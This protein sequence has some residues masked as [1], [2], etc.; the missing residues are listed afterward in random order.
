MALKLTMEISPNVISSSWKRT[1][2]KRFS[3]LEAC[4]EA[5]EE[6]VLLHQLETLEIQE[7]M[8]NEDND[9]GDVME[10]QEA[11]QSDA[12][13]VPKKKP[14]QSQITSFFAKK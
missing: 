3:T 14:I 8:E 10:V 7:E 1:G 5:D 4:E 11:G 12:S 6:A 13:P 9:E 2:I